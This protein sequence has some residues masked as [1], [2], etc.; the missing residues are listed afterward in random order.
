MSTI[1]SDV[2][3]QCGTTQN[4]TPFEVFEL[5]K[6]HVQGEL[7]QYVSNMANLMGLRV[8]GSSNMSIGQWAKLVND[9]DE[10]ATMAW[11][12]AIEYILSNELKKKAQKPHVEFIL[13]K[14]RA[15]RNLDESTRTKNRRKGAQA[16]T[17]YDN[18]TKAATVIMCD[19]RKDWRRRLRGGDKGKLRHVQISDRKVFAFADTGVMMDGE[20]GTLLDTTAE[21]VEYKNRKKTQ[22]TIKIG[23]A[24]VE[25]VSTTSSI[26]MK[27]TC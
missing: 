17:E 7:S 10:N 2:V 25:R 18:L 27:M 6:Q 24:V 1:V 22:F 15:A 21:K 23:R 13:E 4:K 14:F 5:L 11:C 8:K 16:I 19:I 12:F 20:T 26:Y 3:E 9:G